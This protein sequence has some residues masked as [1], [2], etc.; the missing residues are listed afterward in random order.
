MGTYKYI[1]VL[2]NDFIKCD[3]IFGALYYMIPLC[4][5]LVLYEDTLREI[6]HS[7]L[8]MVQLSFLKNHNSL[9]G[10]VFVSLHGTLSAYALCVGCMC[11][12]MINLRLNMVLFLAVV[13]F[14]CVFA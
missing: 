7:S 11:A 5:L 1:Q 13:I 14:F 4:I 6:C 9:C 2:S 10:W 8:I 3:V 12:A